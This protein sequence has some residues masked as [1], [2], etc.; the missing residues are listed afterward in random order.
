M[1]D[2][3]VFLLGESYAENDK[4]NDTSRWISKEVGWPAIDKIQEWLVDKLVASLLKP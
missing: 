1:E 4:W 3:A 2:S